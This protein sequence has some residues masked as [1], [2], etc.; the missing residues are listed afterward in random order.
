MIKYISD[1]T[2]FDEETIV[3]LIDD[4]RPKINSGLFIGFCDGLIDEEECSFDEFKEIETSE[5]DTEVDRAFDFQDNW[6]KERN[7]R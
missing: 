7:K 2:W 6:W 5:M 1:G 4:Y 3:R